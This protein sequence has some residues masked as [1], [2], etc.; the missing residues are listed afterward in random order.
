[1]RYQVS[2]PRAYHLLVLA[3]AAPDL[4]VPRLNAFD[5]SEPTTK[6]KALSL[7]QRFRSQ[8]GTDCAIYR[9]PGRV[10]LIGDHTD[11]ND[12]YVMPAA[13]DLHCWI[14]ALHRPDQKLVLASD[15]FQES[16]EI[17][18]ADDSERRSHSWHDYPVGVAM[19]LKRS[20]YRLQGANLLIR[21][22]VPIGAG[23]SSSAAIEV[24]TAYALMD[25][26]G[27][28]IDR[29]EMA[30]I[31]QKAE[32]EFVGANC[33]IMDQFV[34]LHGR[35]D[36]ALMLDCRS[37]EYELIPIPQ[38]TM[39]VVCN[40]MVKHAVATG[41][42]NRRREECEEALRL[43]SAVLPNLRALRDVNLEQL[44]RHRSLLPETLWRRVHHVVSENGRVMNAAAAFRSAE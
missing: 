23:L 21:G 4:G 40:T 10:N 27:H 15:N 25:L 28:T 24:A 37:L 14:A 30:R 17:D 38:S 5:Q 29:I 35:R 3:P 26:A 34:S 6:E 16:Y 33:G 41:E 39:L 2:S 20:G 13:I 7:A 9:A 36:H 1:V 22:D 11:Y 42:Y 19:Q 18:L 32:N 12:G 31:S 43:L 8:F 44:E